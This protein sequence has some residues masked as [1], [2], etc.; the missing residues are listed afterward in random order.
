MVE[1]DVEIFPATA[2]IRKGR[3]LRVDITPNEEQPGI[4]IFKPPEMR[5]WALGREE[6]ASN[7]VHVRGNRD[8]ESSITLPVVHFGDRK[9][10]GSELTK[11][12]QRLS[13][14]IVNIIRER[15]IKV[16]A[17]EQ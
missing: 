1:V 11:L 3:R 17:Q 16:Q 8:G 7:A 10:D 6:G 13:F 15:T 14:I 5:E 9:A 2:R 12:Q 4:P